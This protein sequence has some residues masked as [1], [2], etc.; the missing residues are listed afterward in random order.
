MDEF[1]SLDPALDT[2][3]SAAGQMTDVLVLAGGVGLRA[4]HLAPG[5]PKFLAPLTPDL[6]VGDH[7]LRHL[8]AQG[9]GRAFLALGYGHEAILA[10]VRAHDAGIK[11]HCDLHRPT[12]T[13]NAVRHALHARYEG[14][15]EWSHDLIVVNGDT[16]LYDVKL[17]ETLS[18]YPCV[19]CFGR[20]RLTNQQRLNG[21]RVLTREAV[22]ALLACDEP[23]LDVWLHSVGAVIW[24]GG[25]FIDTGTPEGHALAV[26]EYETNH[27]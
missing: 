14:H 17:S 25:S 15:V 19:A 11:V 27:A 24:R 8:G 22:N 26:G 9:F 13:A 20:D 18:R 12:S 4:T 23:D 2:N 1:E 5:T 10:H 21:V 6:T 16:L 7:I 3:A